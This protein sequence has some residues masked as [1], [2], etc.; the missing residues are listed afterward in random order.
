MSLRSSS[1]LAAHAQSASPEPSDGPGQSAEHGA[2]PRVRWRW[3][4]RPG[5]L[6]SLPPVHDMLR[7]PRSTHVS[8]LHR[9]VDG[10]SCLRTLQ[11]M[12]G[13]PDGIMRRS[14]RSRRSTASAS[15]APNGPLQSAEA[16]CRAPPSLLHATATQGNEPASPAGIFRRSRQRLGGSRYE[17]AHD[18]LPSEEQQIEEAIRQSLQNGEEHHRA[19]VPEAAPAASSGAQQGRS[20]LRIKLRGA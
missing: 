1:R 16:D 20:G 17:A 2:A 10:D 7:S 13:S 9:E 4:S 15:P 5:S 14:Q 8:S 6:R 11:Q 18:S 12:P 3:S 19:E